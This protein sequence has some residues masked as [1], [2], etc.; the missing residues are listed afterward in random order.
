[1]SETPEIARMPTAL[2][3]FLHGSGGSGLE[4][5][6]IFDTYK[7]KEFGWKTYREV[8][9]ELDSAYL[10]PIA[11]KRPYSPAMGD[12]CNVWFDRSINFVELGLDDRE[13]LEGTEESLKKV[14][15]YFLLSNIFYCTQMLQPLRFC[16]CNVFLFPI[17]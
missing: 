3:I 5:S 6:T 17:R 2:M 14:T 12:E 10:T 15:S 7:I 13:D 1:M 16:S 9:T 11:F 8:L 4:W